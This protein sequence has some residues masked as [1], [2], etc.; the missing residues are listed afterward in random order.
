[1]VDDAGTLADVDLCL[2]HR[3]V[4]H[5][6][7]EQYGWT[8]LT[9]E[10]LLE[11]MLNAQPDA[12]P[13][14]V[15]RL[16]ERQYTIALYEA[17]RQQRD[18]DLRERGYRE[19]HSL[20]Y[21]TADRRWPELAEDAAQRALVLV[22][23]QIDRCRDPGA[24][25][26][27]TLFKLRHA[28]KQE[29]RARGQ[30]EYLE[31]RVQDDVSADLATLPA[32]LEQQDRRRA[33]VAAIQRLPD[34]RQRQAILLKFLSGLSDEEIGERLEIT[35]GYVRVLRHRGLGRLRK[36]QAL[37][38]SASGQDAIGDRGADL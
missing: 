15:G 10:E 12:S 20:L 29:R 34:E 37:A 33:L 9:E 26:A 38:A 21:R 17:C 31:E 28:L 19:L 2:A 30:E 5:D 16:A 24:F 3:C 18:R 8:L 23:E 11:R 7:I 4:V 22:Y 35:V 14:Q 32:H 36:D 25:V 1:M 27:F 6:L 13:D